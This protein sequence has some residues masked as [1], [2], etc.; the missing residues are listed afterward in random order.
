MV[1]R[2]LSIVLTSLLIIISTLFALPV[3]EAKALD[4]FPFVILATGNVRGQLD[5]ISSGP[6]QGEG[7]M[8]K[9]ATIINGIRKEITAKEGYHMLVDAGKSIV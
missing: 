6:N 1:R 3:Q 5:P 8:T 7:G 4:I 2:T 9:A